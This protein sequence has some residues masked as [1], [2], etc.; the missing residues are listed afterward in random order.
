VQLQPD[1]GHPFLQ[2]G[3]ALAYA[4]FRAH[5]VMTQI[6]RVIIVPHHQRPEDAELILAAT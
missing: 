5:P 2:S 3:T 6:H 4:Y 1:I